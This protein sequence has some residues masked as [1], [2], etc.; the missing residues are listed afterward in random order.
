MQNPISFSWEILTSI[1]IEI[2][3]IE[4]DNNIIWIEEE[5][6]QRLVL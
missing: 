5:T 2:L 3:L 4:M 6:N 1:A